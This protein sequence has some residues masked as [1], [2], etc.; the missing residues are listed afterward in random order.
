MIYDMDEIIILH[1]RN[2]ATMVFYNLILKNIFNI[3]DMM[4]D[5]EQVM[6]FP[7]LMMGSIH[8]DLVPSL[9]L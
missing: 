4:L 9:F 6:H 1:F 2:V 7:H 8:I 3:M 5:M